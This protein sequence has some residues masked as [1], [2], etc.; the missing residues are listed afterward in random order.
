MLEVFEK[1]RVADFRK[2]EVRN[3][4][5]DSTYKDLGYTLCII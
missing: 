4:V 3:R 2:E 5:I 1:R